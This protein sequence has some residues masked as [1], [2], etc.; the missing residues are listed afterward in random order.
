[1][2]LIEVFNLSIYG[3]QVNKLSRTAAYQAAAMFTQETYNSTKGATGTSQRNFVGTLDDIRAKD[4]MGNEYVYCS[5]NFFNSNNVSYLNV[6]DLNS[7]DTAEKIHYALF[8]NP[9]SEFYKLVSNGIGNKNSPFYN[10]TN[11]KLLGFG[12]LLNGNKMDVPEL[13]FNSSASL[14][15]QN[16]DYTQVNTYIENMYT[17]A[18]LGIPYIDK[19]VATNMFQYSLTKLLSGCD[20]DNIWNATDSVM[21]NV[22]GETSLRTEDGTLMSPA[23][24]S[25]DGHRIPSVYFHGFRCYVSNSMEGSSVGSNAYARITDIEYKTYDLTKKSKND[26]TGVSDLP[27]RSEFRKETGYYVK[28]AE[29]SMR[30]AN[31]NGIVKASKNTKGGL[32]IAWSSSE[33]IPYTT[34]LYT[35]SGTKKMTLGEENLDNALVTVAT[36]K[37]AVP[38]KYTGITPLAQ[39]FNFVMGKSV[40]G[41]ETGG[42]TESTRG[43]KYSYLS[44]E[45]QLDQSHTGSLYGGDEFT[46]DGELSA[47]YKQDSV[48]FM[49]ID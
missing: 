7:D 41:V 37:Y 15:Q 24:D 3:I 28:D 10:Y 8:Y 34:N 9:N 42:S 11:F 4:T 16:Q 26:S 31:T 47:Y 25:V 35:S 19:N 18:N 13:N 5:A 29:D 21:H 45:A 44:K 40:A 20:P 48:Q 38:M 14:I 22:S 32:G 49:L 6:T 27:G 33:R 17:P 2:S 39:V 43:T 23:L 30:L 1:M 36:I 46:G 12:T